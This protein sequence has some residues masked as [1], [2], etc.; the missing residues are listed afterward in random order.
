MPQ[1]SKPKSNGTL[2]KPSQSPP[3]QMQMDIMGLGTLN[4]LRDEAYYLEQSVSRLTGGQEHLEEDVNNLAVSVDN[5]TEAVDKLTDI[6]EKIYTL[7]N[8]HLTEKDQDDSNMGLVSTSGRKK[9]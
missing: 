6:C 9:K 1:L 4:R 8:D 5:L 2:P 7:L 3:A